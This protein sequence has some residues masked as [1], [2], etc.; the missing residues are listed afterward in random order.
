MPNGE[1]ETMAERLRE[2][3]EP[4]RRAFIPLSDTQV[5]ER[6]GWLQLITPSLRQGGLNEVAHSV[7]ERRRPMPS[8]KAPP[9]DLAPT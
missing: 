9:L 1:L 3:L 7:L 5:I 6:P 2:V 4:P 8:W